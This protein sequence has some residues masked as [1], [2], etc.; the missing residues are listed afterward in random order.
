[1]T[2]VGWLGLEYVYSNGYQQNPYRAVNVGGA[3][4]PEQLPLIRNRYTAVGRLAQLLPASGTT[5]QAIYRFYH[6]DWD[7]TAHTIEGRVYQDLAKYL[8]LRVAYRYYTQGNAF[9]AKLAP[10]TGGPA[11]MAGVDKVYTSDPKMFSL[12]SHYVEFQLRAQLEG[13]KQVPV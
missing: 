1:P 10:T 6:E 3:A 8:D 2:T 7:I 5:F 4:Q 11:Y 12:D 9:F 13:L